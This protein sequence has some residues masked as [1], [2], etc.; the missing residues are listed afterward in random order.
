MPTARAGPRTHQRRPNHA[1]LPCPRAL[2]F[3][4]PLPSPRPF[5]C[6]GT[7]CASPPFAADAGAGTTV[8]GATVALGVASEPAGGRVA[9]GRSP[10]I[11]QASRDTARK[12][13]TVAA[14]SLATQRADAGRS[15]PDR[16]AAWCGRRAVRSAEVSCRRPGPARSSR[17]G[18]ASDL[19]RDPT[20]RV[21]VRGPEHLRH[22]TN[23]PG[24]LGP[25]LTPG[26]VVATRRRRTPA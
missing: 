16:G 11:I 6:S 15:L 13:V 8:V 1:P 3:P 5:P 25:R 19:D 12:A 20:V 21:G 14:R 24:P 17:V 10:P 23:R 26:G 9:G 2:P 7:G 22:P 4:C 18:E